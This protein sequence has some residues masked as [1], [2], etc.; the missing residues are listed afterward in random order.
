MNK[1]KCNGCGK[2]HPTKPEACDCGSDKGFTEVIVEI[3]KETESVDIEAMKA[4]WLKEQEAETNKKI[5]EEKAKILESAE[6][7]EAEKLKAQREAW[8]KEYAENSKLSASE[9]KAKEME[10][11][12]EAQSKIIEEQAKNMEMLMKNKEENDS[13]LQKMALKDELNEVVK[14]KVWMSDLVKEAFDK[15]TLNTIE[16]YNALCDSTLGKMAKDYYDLKEQS[17]TWGQDPANTYAKNKVGNVDSNK[18]KI[19]DS[20]KK[21]VDKMLARAG[22]RV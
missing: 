10:K 17:K 6:L 7:S 13:K 18:P 3:Q 22:V 14:E 5:D 15:G 8:E 4:E 16:D 20:D 11:E 2:I 19:S 21:E 12:F 9:K 1:Y